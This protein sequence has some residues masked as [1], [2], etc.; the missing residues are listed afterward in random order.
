MWSGVG[1]ICVGWVGYSVVWGS[2]VVD[3][4]CV[5]CEFSVDFCVE[6]F[7]FIFEIY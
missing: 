2:I 5:L 6:C 4:L 1:G 7:V 3:G